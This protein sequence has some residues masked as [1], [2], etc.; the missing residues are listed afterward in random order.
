MTR[1]PTQQRA[2]DDLLAVDAPRPTPDPAWPAPLRARLEGA[3]RSAVADLPPEV[4]L[5]LNKSALDALNCDGRYLDLRAQPFEWSPRLLLGKLAHRAIELDHAG[6]FQR[7]VRDLV[8]H[9]WMEA[10]TDRGSAAA[11]VAELGGVAADGLRGAVSQRVISFRE[12]F[13]AL[14]PTAEVRSEKPYLVRLADG[15]VELRGVPD[16]VLGRAMATER[17]MLL[18]DIKTGGRGPHHLHDMRFYALLATLATG[19]AP[20]RVATY[21][22]DEAGWEHEDITFDH[23]EAAA[24]TVADKL[25][26]AGALGRQPAPEPL[27]LV[28]GPACRWCRRAP[29]CPAAAMAS[30]VAAVVADDAAG[31]TDDVAA[32]VDE[33]AAVVPTWQTTLPPS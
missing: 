9:A 25:V 23:L 28:P 17:R 20:F 32:L 15:R 10:A 8:A 29:D 21:Y 13:P 2:W 5:R 3:A 19:I 22:L 30:D 31:L 4:T 12:S 33:V 11:F 18:V 26:R 14:P 7:P 16:L 6:G 1:T 27:R 24:R